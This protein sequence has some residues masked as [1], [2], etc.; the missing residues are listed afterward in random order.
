MFVLRDFPA[1]AQVAIGTVQE[2]VSH[3]ICQTSIEI[4]FAS[5]MSCFVRVIFATNIFSLASLKII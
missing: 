3:E 5:Q 1:K 4:S 2:R